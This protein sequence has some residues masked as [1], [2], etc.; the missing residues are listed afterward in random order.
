MAELIFVVGS[1]L[2]DG[3]GARQYL[4]KAGY[5]VRTFPLSLDISRIQE[6][7]PSLVLIGDQLP[8]GDALELC[9]RIREISAPRHTVIILHTQHNQST[10]DARHAGA[11]YVLRN[12]VTPRKLL[13]LVQA[14]L[15]RRVHVLP[16]EVGDI[17]I[18]H[19]AMTLWVRGK[20]ILTTTLEFRLLNYLALHRGHTFTRDFLLDAVWGQSR[21]VTPR[22][23]DACIRRVREKIEPDTHIPTYLKTVRGVGYRFD[24][25]ASW[26]TPVDDC[27]CLAC[28]PSRESKTRS[29]RLKRAV[30]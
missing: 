18:D 12:P 25:V 7:Q 3:L 2:T 27:R 4:E 29:E 8:D 1:V 19:N 20:E 30:S 24:A 28:T 16:V 22:S 26:P 5:F 6:D 15:P 14:A 17:V 11:D 9:R 13:N 23:V 21:F 10:G